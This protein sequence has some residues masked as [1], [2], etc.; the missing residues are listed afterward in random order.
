M[1]TGRNWEDFCLVS[2]LVCFHVIKYFAANNLVINLDKINKIKFITQKPLILHCIFVIIEYKQE[3]MNK[4]FLVLKVD[5]HIIC[6]INIEQMILKLKRDCYAF[7]CTAYISKADTL[8]CICKLP[9]C[10]KIWNNFLG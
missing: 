6:N 3:R 2:N 9:F 5:N 1:I 4:K 10:Y 7:S 8:K